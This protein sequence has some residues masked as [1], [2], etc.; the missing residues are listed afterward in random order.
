MPLNNQS[1]YQNLNKFK[2][3]ITKIFFFPDKISIC[4]NN[5]QHLEYNARDL[6]YV[7]LTR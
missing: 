5:N 6:T 7:L 2:L 4:F 1:Y 3:K